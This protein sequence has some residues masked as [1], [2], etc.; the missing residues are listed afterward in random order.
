MPAVKLWC[1]LTVVGPRGVA[2]GT[3]VL[4]GP[5]SPDLAVVDSLARL[6]LA[7]GR[8]GG[9]VLLSDVSPALADLFDLVGLHWE[10]V[11]QPEDGEEPLGVE[12]EVELPDPPA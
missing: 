2:V 9:R 8:G 10:V 7:A 11:W 1:R 4:S 12:K 5:S 3:W 6:Q